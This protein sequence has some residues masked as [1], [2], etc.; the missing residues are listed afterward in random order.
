MR[1]AGQVVAKVFTTLKPLCV[2][3]VSTLALANK[4]DEVIRKE[5]GIP[6]FL[7]YQGYPGV[8]CVSVNDTLVHGIPSDKIILHDGDI[9]SLDVGVTLNGYCA[10]ACRTYV[11]GIAK[12]NAKR[13][14]KVTEECFFTGVKLIQPGIHLGDVSHAIQAYAESHGYSVP[15]DYT[16]HGIGTHLH[17]DPSIPNYGLSGTGPILKEGMCLAI[18]PMIA[19]G[20]YATRILSDG[21]TAKMK[22]GKLSSHY[23]NTLVVTKTGYEI[24]TMSPTE[25]KEIK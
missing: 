12:E 17:E 15:R 4:A 2:P 7:D 14:V 25:Q 1:Q 6:T 24:L 11:V 22:D 3:G 16:G 9:V 18:E 5:G 13:L 19:E 20:R 10:D 23:E 8:I 21:W